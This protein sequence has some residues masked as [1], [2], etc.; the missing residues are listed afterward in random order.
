[1][2]SE[3]VE[4]ANRKNQF[5][6]ELYTRLAEI[7]STY[8]TYQQFYG[9]LSDKEIFILHTCLEHDCLGA[10]TSQWGKIDVQLKKRNIQISE[11]LDVPGFRFKYR[12][13]D[14][15]ARTPLPPLKT[16]QG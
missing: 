8:E 9:E 15:D 5:D 11:Y 4:A 2:I 1:M 14:V 6:K 12:W 10:Y 3:L 16:T 7:A 13:T